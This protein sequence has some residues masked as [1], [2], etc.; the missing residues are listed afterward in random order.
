M[1]TVGWEINCYGKKILEKMRYEVQGAEEEAASSRN[2]SLS[3]LMRRQGN[4]VGR[5]SGRSFS[6]VVGGPLLPP[7]SS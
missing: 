3:C 4:S 6:V 7:C 5:A 1:G 2:R